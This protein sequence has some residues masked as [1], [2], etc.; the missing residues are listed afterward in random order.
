[1]ANI[2]EHESPDDHQPGTSE[3]D[4]THTNSGTEPIE[5]L[6]SSEMFLAAFA[7]V[8]PIIAGD[9]LDP[10]FDLVACQREERL[11]EEILTDE[12]AGLEE[13]RA[14]GRTLAASRSD[15]VMLMTVIDEAVRARLA[16]SHRTAPT[17]TLAMTARRSG[18]RMVVHTESIGDIA[19]RMAELW[20]LL[21]AADDDVDPPEAVLL[22]E[23]REGYDHLAAEIEAGRRIPAGL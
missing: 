12:T 2:P 17:A 7:G 18:P 15:I 5:P 20:E 9:I 6:P 16:R 13:L 14:A 22:L 3:S 11:A 19:A 21:D 23:L 8:R 4:A 1:M 10:A